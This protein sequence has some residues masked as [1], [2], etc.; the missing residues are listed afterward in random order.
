MANTDVNT[1]SIPSLLKILVKNPFLKCDWHYQ[2]CLCVYEINVHLNSS[3]TKSRTSMPS[4]LPY[5]VEIVT[6]QNVHFI[7]LMQRYAMTSRL[8]RQIQFLKEKNKKS[9]VK[10]NKRAKIVQKFNV[11]MHSSYS[12]HTCTV[13]H[14]L[15]LF[16]SH[17]M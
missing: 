12:T 7:A 4:I 9:P 16:R 6:H 11:D 15:C 5:I 3:T 2:V 17:N 10:V 8:L 1:N 13:A 14:I